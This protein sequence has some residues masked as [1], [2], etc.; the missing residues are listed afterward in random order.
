MSLV[1]IADTSPVNCLLETGYIDVL[2]S[3]YGQIIL[4][5]TVHRELSDRGS[6]DTVRQWV[7]MLPAWISVQTLASSLHPPA[8]VHRGDP[9]Y[10]Q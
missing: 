4:P 6:S 2:P 3:L 10:I 5:T 9:M 7:S 8:G 1:V